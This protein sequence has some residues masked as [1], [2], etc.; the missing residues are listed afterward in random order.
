MLQRDDYLAFRSRYQPLDLRLIIVGESPPRSGKYFYNPDGRSSEPLFSALMVQLN[1]QAVSKTH[2]LQCMQDEGWLLIDST[3]EP[4][5][6]YSDRKRNAVIVRDY[7]LLHDDLAKLTPGRSTPVVLIKANVC[8]L[9]EPRLLKDGFNVVNRGRRI[10]F[11][12]H[13][14]QGRFRSQFSMAL[15]LANPLHT[16]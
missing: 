4:V 2:G 10:Y 14:Q 1:V 7:P 11:P 3:Y 8:R 16:S 5:D 12:S 9:L 15:Q 6:G 13:G